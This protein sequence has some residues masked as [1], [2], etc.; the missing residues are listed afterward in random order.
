MATV[1][2]EYAGTD[3]FI[4]YC[5]P[6]TSSSSSFPGTKMFS[7]CL[8][9]L[10]PCLAAPFALCYLAPS[11]VWEVFNEKG[12]LPGSLCVSEAHAKER[13]LVIFRINIVARQQA[14]PS[15]DFSCP[16]SRF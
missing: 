11:S 6:A 1:K 8:L 16:F 5:R 15:P 10:T 7:W 13:I 14:L 9:L 2:S 4:A 3:A 12:C